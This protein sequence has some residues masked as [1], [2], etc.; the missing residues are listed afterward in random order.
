MFLEPECVVQGCSGR[1][2]WKAA[3]C[4]RITVKESDWNIYLFVE[5]IVI[6]N[7]PSFGLDENWVL[8][9]TVYGRH[10]VEKWLK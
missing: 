7:S 2:T 6:S 10:L 8:L 1:D 3:H 5:T 4:V 9:Y